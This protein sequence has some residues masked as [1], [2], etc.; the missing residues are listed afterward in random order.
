[1]IQYWMKDQIAEVLTD[2]VVTADYEPDEKTYVTVFY[3]GGSAPGPFDS[4]L[5]TLRYMVWVESDDWGFAEYAA[6]MVHKTL[7]GYPEQP[8][9]AVDYIDKDGKLLFMENV[10]I[11]KIT[12]QGDLNPLGVLEGKRR[13]SVNFDAVLSTI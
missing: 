12:A 8:V 4:T 1:M 7:N 13:Y 11:L 2:L 10:Q 3:E 5:Q 6:R 9:I